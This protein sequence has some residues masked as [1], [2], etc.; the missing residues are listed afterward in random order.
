MI[1]TV[2]ALSRQLM[3]EWLD[4]NYVAVET[5]LGDLTA[6]R[7]AVPYEQLF[8]EIWHYLFG[9]ANRELVQSGQFADPYEDERVSKG[10]IPFAFETAVLGIQGDGGR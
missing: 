6:L 9:L 1:D 7:Y 3:V 5:G 2:R 8:T 4:S 10:M